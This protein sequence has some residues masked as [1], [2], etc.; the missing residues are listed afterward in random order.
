MFKYGF[1]EFDYKLKELF[2]FF[3]LFR[4]IVNYIL[5]FEVCFKVKCFFLRVVCCLFIKLEKGILVNVLFLSLELRL[6]RWLLI[7]MI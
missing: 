7:G 4:G 2:V 5:I 3:I 6:S 1:W